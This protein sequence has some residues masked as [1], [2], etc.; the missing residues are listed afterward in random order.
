MKLVA[1]E[2]VDRQIIEGLRG[3]GYNALSLTAPE[4]PIF[5]IINKKELST[6]LTGLTGSI[7]GEPRCN[8]FAFLRNYTGQ[9]QLQK[10]RKEQVVLDMNHLTICFY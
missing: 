9:M 5:A 8:S 7:L 3:Q 1:D 2:S 10:V 6:G 4:G